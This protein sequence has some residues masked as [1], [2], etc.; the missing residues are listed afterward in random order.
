M[1]ARKKQDKS[2]SEYNNPFK[3]REIDRSMRPE[4]IDKEIEL[5]P[6]RYI[7]SKTDQKG[8]IQYGNEYFVEISGYK[9]SE[10]VGKPHNIIRHPDMPKAIFKLMW[11]RLDARK[12]V[13]ALVKNL[14]KS[15][16]YYW[17]MTD[18]DVKVNK[19]TNETLGYFAYRRA[20]PKHAVKS[21]EKLYAKLVEI[22]K[23]SGVKGSESYL[24]GYLEDRGQTYDEYIDEITKNR[25]MLKLWFKAMKKF[26]T[27][28]EEKRGSSGLV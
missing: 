8:I 3:P 17:V 16:R 9:E 25:G 1:L 2:A 19:A 27:S 10:L 18:F 11:D 13:I 26:F 22:E 7:V 20:A 15:G 28:K 6:K 21:I 5:D 23:E 24:M 12:N 14:S 4:P